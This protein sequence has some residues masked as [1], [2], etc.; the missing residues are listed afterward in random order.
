MTLN[1]FKALPGSEMSELMNKYMEN[2]TAR[3]FKSAD[4]NFTFAQAEKAMESK[5][6][7]KLGG[8]YRTEDEMLTFFE[9][10]RKERNKKELS[11]DNIEQLLQLLEP[12]TFER[13]KSLA[14][15]YNYV[16]SFIL[17]ED[18]GIRIKTGEEEDVRSTSFRVYG[19]T[20]DRWKAFVKEN[21]GYTAT[22]LLNTALLEF[23]DRHG[24]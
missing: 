16:S 15:K 12:G 20:M 21:R 1:E 13:L 11:Q 18:R 9:E 14:E 3:N 8:V 5:G 10:K 22:D 17:R 7:Y 2:H 6:V 23:M 19:R 4:M 24:F